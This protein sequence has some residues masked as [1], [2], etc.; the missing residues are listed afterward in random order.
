MATPLSA[1][2]PFWSI[3]DD[4]LPKL[5]VT[6]ESLQTG[7]AEASPELAPSI[8][9]A[10]A[11]PPSI[12]TESGAAVMT[13]RHT[14][15]ILL[16]MCSYLPDPESGTGFTRVGSNTKTPH[17]SVVPLRPPDRRKLRGFPRGSPGRRA[18]HSLGRSW[19]RSCL[20]K[21]R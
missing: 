4:P 17:R 12:K 15:L 8:G 9:S 20:E 18:H 11:R 14:V 19:N 13:P 2:F 1:P 6:P 16:R 5:T 21:Y 10:F 7:T 3:S